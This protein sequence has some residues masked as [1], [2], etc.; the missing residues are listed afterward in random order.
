MSR[1]DEL[2][3]DLVFIGLNR[4]VAAV[5]SN[6]GEIVWEWKAPKGSGFVNVLPIEGN[7]L[8]VS[9]MGYTYCLDATNGGQFWYNGLSGFGIGVAS[10]TTMSN[11]GANSAAAAAALHAQAA[12]NSASAAGA[13]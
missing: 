10:L 7:R 3:K 8:I 12:A 9:V 6:N 11:S 1:K 13:S 5:N 4:R 2:I